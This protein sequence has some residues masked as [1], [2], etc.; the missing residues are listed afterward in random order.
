[1]GTFV[2]GCLFQDMYVAHTLGRQREYLPQEQVRVS[3]FQYNK[4]HMLG[5]PSCDMNPLHVPYQPDLLCIAPRGLGNE[6][7]RCR[8]G[9]QAACRAVRGQILYLC[10]RSLVFPPASMKTV[11]G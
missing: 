9:T 8:C 1:M 2:L 6:G 11:A 10:L 3:Y 7:R 4:E 5:F